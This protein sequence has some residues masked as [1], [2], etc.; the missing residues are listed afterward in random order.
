MSLHLI[1]LHVNMGIH[2]NILA[3]KTFFLDLLH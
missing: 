1:V 3:L 2:Q